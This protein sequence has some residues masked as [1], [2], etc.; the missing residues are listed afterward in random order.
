MNVVYCCLVT[1]ENI[2]TFLIYFQFCQMTDME[3]AWDLEQ[4]GFHILT[5]AQKLLILKV[6]VVTLIDC[7]WIT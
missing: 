1:S 3:F 2:A 4:F 6:C 7:S 5:S